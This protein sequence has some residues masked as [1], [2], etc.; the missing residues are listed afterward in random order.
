MSCQE[1]S[2]LDFVKANFGAL[3][4]AHVEFFTRFLVKLRRSF[5]GDLDLLLIMA[6]IGEVTLPRRHLPP[7]FAYE[8]LIAG[9]GQ[10]IPK[11]RIKTQSIADFTGMPR[12]T[13]RRKL[14]IL[15][16]KG[17]LERGETGNWI[18]SR[19]A[20]EELQH[21]T[22]ASLAYLAVI[23]DAARQVWA[24]H[25]EGDRNSEQLY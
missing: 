9:E 7:D 20:S 16:E 2:T 8:Q 15:H 12:E 13:V 18:A 22:E 23:I 14:Q 3:W 25:G 11:D 1:T 6:V 17:W 19:K 21:A 5:D 10:S 24:E 4:P